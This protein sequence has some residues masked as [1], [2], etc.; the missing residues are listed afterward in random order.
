[1]YV[2]YRRLATIFLIA[3]IALSICEGVIHQTSSVAASPINA[4]GAQNTWSRAPTNPAFAQYLNN[5][6]AG[7]VTTTTSQQGL[8]LI[9]ATVNFSTPVSYT[10]LTLPTNREV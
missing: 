2:N 8:G 5:Q 10:H 6:G 9:P 4:T 1:M 7:N 3:L